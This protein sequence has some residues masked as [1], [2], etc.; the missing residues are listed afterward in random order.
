MR[1]LLIAAIAI[2]PLAGCAKRA[3][4]VAPAFIQPGSFA[5]FGCV[6]LNAMAAAERRTL[7][8][9]EADQNSAATGDTI[10][11]LFVGVPISS[12]TGQDVEA[13]LAI[14]KGKMLEIEAAQAAKGC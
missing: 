3:S 2:V 14:S 5:A 6:E 9:L 13:N 1:S 4:E 12:V 8:T 11:V 7:A 10:G